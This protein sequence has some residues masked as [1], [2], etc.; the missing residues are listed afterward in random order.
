MTMSLARRM[1]L[2]VTVA[3]IALVAA[4]AKKN[5]VFEPLPASG[6][7][8][9][10]VVKDSGGSAIADAVVT[11]ETMEGGV[12]AS[13]RQSI[14]TSRRRVAPMGGAA[15]TALR[16]TVTD[17][18]GHYAFDGVAS[19]AYLLSASR[20]HHLA[21]IEH[22]QVPAGSQAVAVNIVLT[23]TGSLYGVATLENATNHQSTVVYVEGTSFVA[24]T[25]PSGAYIVADVPIGTWT[26]RATHGGYLDAS[27]SG[28]IAAAGDSIALAP[29]LLRLDSNI[30]PVATANPV[31]TVT[32]TFLSV[33]GGSG[34]DADGTVVRYEWDF[35]NDGVFDY[36]SSTSASVSHVYPGPGTYVA[37]LR[38]TDDHGAVGMSAVNVTVNPAVFV[39]AT[40]GSPSNPGTRAQP[41]STISGGLSKAVAT[42]HGAV[43]LAG[44]TYNESPV[45]VNGKSVIGGYDAT[46]WVVTGALTQVNV[47]TTSA[48]C[49]GIS[50]NT[51]I[52]GLT[53]IAD[54]SPSDNS[55]AFLISG[56]S[57]LSFSQCVFQSGNGAPG[58]DGPLNGSNGIVG[59]AGGPGQ[60]GSCDGSNGA[61][62]A[63]GVGP[64][65]CLGGA[66]GA[67][68]V[69]GANDG[70]FGTAG[71]C[72]GGSAGFGGFTGDPAV[73]G[74]NGGNGA[75]GANGANS[76]AA[77]ASGSIIGGLWTPLNSGPGSAG[78]S[79]RGGGGGGGGGGQ[80]GDLPGGGNGG[81]GG[82][83]GGQ[84]GGSGTGGNGGFASFAV[85]LFN[86]Q[87]TFTN[88]T[89]HS[90]N[91]GNGGAGRNGGNG[92]NG[93]T[94][95]LGASVC[96]SEVG[97]GG[98]GGNGGKGGSGGG[99]AGGP[100]GPSFGVYGASGSVPTITG[101]TFIIGSGGAGGAGGLSPGQSA[102]PSG[103]NGATG[104]I[105]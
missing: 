90:G 45:F 35:E 2:L 79:G 39:S 5:D 65:G 13:V 95:G 32:E 85:F 76:S 10:G 69:Q 17:A 44:G 42:G 37:K 36:S 66:G 6:T 99:G 84:G 23:P 51:L 11:L 3:S 96:T 104:N 38:V 72:S 103:P 48:T 70:S 54:D 25:A 73:A 4:C 15:T 30:P 83:G 100:G 20:A 56:S 53:F 29:M 82:G 75:T 7:V 67:G 63:P 26:V 57:A 101:A 27:T 86:S 91:G 19:G 18:T 61:G 24:V 21:G 81:G 34:T 58:A 8:V 9:E 46:T 88:C 71:G 62:G 80:G 89:F 92:G 43:F 52:Q 22:V 12:A 55:I 68:G 102:A 94:G 16:S 98:N 28:A 60:P 74:S 93:G 105:H 50:S 64:G 97:K 31:A 40:T 59:G 47:G 49:N 41:L 14:D 78:G 77:G 1:G 33:L 87:A